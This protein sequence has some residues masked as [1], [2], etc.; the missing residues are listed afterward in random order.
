MKVVTDGTVSSD[1]WSFSTRNWRC[2]LAVSGAYPHAGGLEWDTNHD[3][4]IDFTDLEY[5]A[6]DWLNI[7]LGSYRLQ[8]VYFSWFANEWRQCANRTDGGCAGF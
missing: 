1:I 8:F 7:E 5:F 2:P 6:D 4:V 3:C